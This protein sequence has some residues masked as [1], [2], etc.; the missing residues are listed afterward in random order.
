MVE[1]PSERWS[2]WASDR[3]IDL[4]EMHVERTH[5]FY[6]NLTSRYPFDMLTNA[7]GTKFPN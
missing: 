4:V 1:S 2:D 7:L 6:H 5:I 3:A